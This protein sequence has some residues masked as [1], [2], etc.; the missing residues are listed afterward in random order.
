MVISDVFPMSVLG[1]SAW[2]NEF[3]SASYCNLGLLL[4]CAEGR[5]NCSCREA[6]KQQ[7]I[8]DSFL[9]VLCEIFK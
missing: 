8:L 1:R 6:L 3:I 7:A 9:A 5:D 2:T 4:T